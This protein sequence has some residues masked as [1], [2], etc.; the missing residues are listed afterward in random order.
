MSSANYRTHFRT[1][2]ICSELRVA[3][4]CAEHETRCPKGVGDTDNSEGF[5]ELTAFGGG[6]TNGV[7]E[8][9]R[10]IRSFLAAMADLPRP[11][12]AQA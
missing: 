4:E 11:L 6:G 10:M 5:R 12:R 2:S 3:F 9:G 7:A 1:K 8:K